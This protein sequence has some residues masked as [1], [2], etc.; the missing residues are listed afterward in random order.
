MARTSFSK[1][2]PTDIQRQVFAR[3]RVPR[4]PR[5]RRSLQIGIKCA[6]RPGIRT[7]RIGEGAWQ[8]VTW[9]PL[10]KEVIMSSPQAESENCK[11]RYIRP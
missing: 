3:R 6:R 8:V 7:G 9:P 11:A 5:T 4:R 1:A 2:I 10:I